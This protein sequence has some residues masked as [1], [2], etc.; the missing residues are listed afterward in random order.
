MLES[1]VPQA[2]AEEVVVTSEEVD[3]QELIDTI[4]KI[5]IGKYSFEI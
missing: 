2:V 5:H 4:D 1:D 3:E